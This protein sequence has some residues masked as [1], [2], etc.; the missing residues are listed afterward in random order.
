M[1]T[2]ESQTLMEDEMINYVRF[3][4]ILLP[5]KNLSEFTLNTLPFLSQVV[6]GQG[7]L[8]Y[9][10]DLRLLSPQFFS[11]GIPE[12]IAPAIEKMVIEQSDALVNQQELHEISVPIPA[13]VWNDRNLILYPLRSGDNS[14]GF[15]GFIFE[16]S[17]IVSSGYIGAIIPTIVHSVDH[18]IE[19]ARSDR[20]LKQLNA[21]L[22][23][24]SMLAQS[25][26]LHELLEAALYCVM[27]IVSAETASVLLLD[28]DKE[29]FKFYH[30]EGPTKSLLMT[31]TFPADKGLAGAVLRTGQSEII[32]DTR[33][34]PRFYGKIDAE[35]GFQTRNMIAI[36]LSAGKEKIGVLEVINKIDSDSFTEEEE[37]LLLSIAEEIAFAIR[38]AKIF[39]YVADT[40]CRQRQGQNSCKG[41]KRPL[42]TWTPCVKYRELDI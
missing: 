7:A 16:G 21:Y 39:E 35:S 1:S 11:S 31:A 40:Y 25:L 14:I 17:A 23:V 28:D 36:P 26:G 2:E 30:V 6:K 33:S 8:L 5:A 10:N 12:N 41:C 9:I 34:D 32:N 18:L 29:H 42:G 38:N 37:L 24:S 27:D 13:E 3:V 20:Q 19:Q 4:E 22:N 15:S